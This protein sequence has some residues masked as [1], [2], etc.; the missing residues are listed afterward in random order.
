[1]EEMM[2]AV[3]LVVVP[4]MGLEEKLVGWVQ[5]KREVQMEEVQ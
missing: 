5:V 3:V 1:M 4:A 2:A